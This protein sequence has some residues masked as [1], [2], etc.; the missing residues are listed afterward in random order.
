MRDGLEPG[1]PRLICRALAKPSLLVYKWKKKGMFFDIYSSLPFIRRIWFA[2]QL[3]SI[4]FGFL[5]WKVWNVVCLCWLVRKEKGVGVVHAGWPLIIKEPLP[6]VA[7]FSIIALVV[8][9][10]VFL[11]PRVGFTRDFGFFQ[12]F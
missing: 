8:P 5:H 1:L 6:L 7:F 12:V 10:G 11:V 2:K 3:S 9:N 4:L